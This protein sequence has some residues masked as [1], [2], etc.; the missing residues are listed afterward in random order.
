MRQT[1]FW[2]CFTA[3]CLLLLLP[4]CVPAESLP[5]ATPAAMPTEIRAVQGKLKNQIETLEK[6][7]PR[8][9]SGGYLVP[10]DAEMADFSALLAALQAGDTT[11]A[12]QLAFR[13]HYELISYTDGADANAVSYLLREQE[14]GQMGWGLYALR[15]NPVNNIII[16]APHPLADDGSPLIAV[17]LYRALDARALL[18]A[19][20]H[21][22]ANPNQAADAA[23][24]PQSIFQ[25]VH[26]SLVKKQDF[27]TDAP[28]VLQVHGFAASKH[29]KYPQVVIGYN[30]QVMGLFENL[31]ARQLAQTLAD[32]LQ[33]RGINASVCDGQNWLDL[34]GE[35]N[36]QASA[37]P[38]GIFLHLEMDETIRGD[39][40]ALMDAL[41]QV[42]RK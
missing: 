22:D 15:A 26:Q 32:A 21:R 41:N 10:T 19:G 33:A 20:A 8:A 35:T 13:N 14:S 17:D 12:L 18:V 9:N 24:T 42:L 16:E 7:M 38:D 2:S 28:V 5:T 40:G 1:F 11:T 36:A 25:A 37:M 23:H 3:L 34:C 39:D 4:G 6:H 31:Q 30:G 27:L 29:P